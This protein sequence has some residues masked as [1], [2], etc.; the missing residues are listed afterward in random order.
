MSLS[1][2]LVHKLARNVRLTPTEWRHLLDAMGS[3]R[4]EAL[5]I[6]IERMCELGI[7]NT[8]ILAM[9]SPNSL[10]ELG[11]EDPVVL[12]GDADDVITALEASEPACAPRAR[13][14]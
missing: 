6:D 4:P 13:S 5:G 14:A 10:R 2:L 3:P 12:S 9:V 8:S 1:T 11:I 7:E